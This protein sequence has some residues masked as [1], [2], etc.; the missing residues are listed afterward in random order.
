LQGTIQN[1]EVNN[2]PGVLI[3]RVLPLLEQARKKEKQ[4]RQLELLGD[5]RERLRFRLHSQQQELFSL[6]RELAKHG[7]LHNALRSLPLC[8]WLSIRARLL[9]SPELGGYLAPAPMRKLRTAR[10]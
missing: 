6:L 1:L 3:E 7:Q 10:Y 9:F 8:Q 2:Q 5:P 4:K